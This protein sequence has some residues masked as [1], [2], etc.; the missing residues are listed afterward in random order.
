MIRQ[1]VILVAL[2]ALFACSLVYSFIRMPRQKRVKVPVAQVQ[3]A[4]VAPRIPAGRGDSSLAVRFD[5]LDRG[6]SLPSA[7]S[8]NIFQPL[9]GKTPKKGGVPIPLPPPPPPPVKIVEP[10]PPPVVQAPQVA[11]PTPLQRDMA[12]F[13][14]LGHLKKDNVKT[15]FLSNGKDIF[16]VKKGDKIANKYHVTALS[17]ASIT[18]SSLQDTGDIVIPLVE[19]RPLAAPKR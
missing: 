4:A 6:Q 17:D 16:V 12:S 15:I 7:G 2:L 11:Q 14:Y 13:T 18:I 10:A 3:T 1:R 19:N 8:R 5:L 9:Y